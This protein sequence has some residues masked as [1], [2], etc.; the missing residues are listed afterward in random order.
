VITGII[1]IT[2]DY[3]MRQTTLSNG[4]TVSAVGIGGHYKHFEY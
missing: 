2:E 4:K 1:K 3:I